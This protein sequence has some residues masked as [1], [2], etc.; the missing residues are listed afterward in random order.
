MNSFKAKARNTMGNEESEEGNSPIGTDQSSLPET[1][2]TPIQTVKKHF[3]FHTIVIPE[4]EH[5]DL[6]NLCFNSKVIKKEIPIKEA[7]VRSKKIV[8]QSL[9][10]NKVLK[11]KEISSAPKV[12]VVSSH[13]RKPIRSHPPMP[14]VLSVSID[15][16]RKT[17]RV[18]IIKST[19]DI[20]TKP[21]IY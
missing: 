21:K 19:R 10:E 7:A 6:T 3:K 14:D 4:R 20:A 11:R 1:G 2:T 15:G 5:Y 12:V 18:K 8:K 17:N 9:A 13:I 16:T